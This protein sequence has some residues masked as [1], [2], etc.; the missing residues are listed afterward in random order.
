MACEVRM[1][2]R[3]RACVA[4]TSVECV[5]IPV[6]ACV[7]QHT[8]TSPSI[9]STTDMTT[10]LE[11]G[12]WPVAGLLEKLVRSTSTFLLL[13]K[14]VRARAVPNLFNHACSILVEYYLQLHVL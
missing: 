14:I 9:A 6:S 13:C 3:V 7:C 4:G 2:V 8:C 12:S 10:T 11:I 5:S 1:R